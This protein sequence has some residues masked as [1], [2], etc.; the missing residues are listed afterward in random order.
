M[1]QDTSTV[2]ILHCIKLI[3][4]VFWVFSIVTIKKHVSMEN[5]TSSHDY[6]CSSS[7]EIPHLLENLKGDDN[8]KR[9]TWKCEHNIHSINVPTKL[10]VYFVGDC[11]VQKN[12]PLTLIKSLPKKSNPPIQ[13]LSNTDFNIIFL[14]IPSGSSSSGFLSQIYIPFFFTIRMLHIYH[15]PSYDYVRNS[16]RTVTDMKLTTQSSAP[17]YSYLPLTSNVLL[18]TL[19]SQTHNLS[20]FLDV[21]HQIS[22]PHKMT[23]TQSVL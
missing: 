5:S 17:L 16:L 7:Q 18:N 23:P 11:N 14:S 22:H 9:I 21:T 8:Y 2:R 3:I 12:P 1:K 10:S 20:S 19:L 4:A 13:L 15:L 6:S